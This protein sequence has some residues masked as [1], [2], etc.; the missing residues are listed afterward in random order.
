MSDSMPQIKR[1]L[2]EVG[3]TLEWKTKFGIGVSFGTS[4]NDDCL[5][6]IPT[7]LRNAVWINLS[8]TCV[9]DAGLQLLEQASVLEHLNV[10]GTSVTT[11]GVSQLL[12]SAKTICKL[13]LPDNLGTEDRKRIQAAWPSVELV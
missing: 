6:K 1:E 9:T 13:E 10:M 8:N 12:E 11:A 4:T 3:G 7:C 2:A 5:K